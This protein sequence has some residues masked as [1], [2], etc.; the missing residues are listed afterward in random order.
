MLIGVVAKNEDQVILFSLIAMFF[1]T[2]MG[3]AWFPLEGT[4]AGFYN[5]ARLTP[6][7][8]HAGFSKYHCT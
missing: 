5:I 4:S 7:H 6:A 8:N 3:G 2:A 1:F